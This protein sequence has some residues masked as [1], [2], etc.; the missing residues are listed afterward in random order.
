MGGISKELFSPRKFF[1][2][3][4]QKNVSALGGLKGYKRLSRWHNNNINRKPVDF[5]PFVDFEK[6]VVVEAR[7]TNIVETF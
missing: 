5:I 2:F 1:F 3:F 6:V 7:V 4:F